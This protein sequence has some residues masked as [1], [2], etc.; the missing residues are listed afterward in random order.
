M[1][2]EAELTR[3]SNPDRSELAAAKEATAAEAAEAG[4]KLL[5]FVELVMPL[6]PGVVPTTGWCT[7]LLAISMLVN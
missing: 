5:L 6:E 2:S 7:R 3:P 1:G 4:L